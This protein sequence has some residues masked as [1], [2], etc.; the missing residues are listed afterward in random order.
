MKANSPS[1][2]SQT[3]I[4]SA[5]L[6]YVHESVSIIKTQTVRN[7]QSSPKHEMLKYS[8]DIMWIHTE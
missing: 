8:G 6:T 7:V 4:F 1:Y 3:V 2:R 5:Y